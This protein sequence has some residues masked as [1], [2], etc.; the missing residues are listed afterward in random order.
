MNSFTQYDWHYP[1]QWANCRIQTWRRSKSRHECSAW[2]SL[3]VKRFLSTRASHLSFPVSVTGCH[4]PE[5]LLLPQGL[6][7]RGLIAAITFKFP[8]PDALL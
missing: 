1:G 2:S 5:D 7:M 3:N 8:C 6:G 4:V